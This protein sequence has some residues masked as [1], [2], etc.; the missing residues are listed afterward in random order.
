MIILVSFN[1]NNKLASLHCTHSQQCVA[2][3]HCTD[4]LSI[5]VK[6]VKCH[7]YDGFVC[8]GKTL[9]EVQRIQGIDSVSLSVSATCFH[10][11]FRENLRY[12]ANTLGALYLWH[13]F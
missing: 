2:A 9:P 1:P 3:V 8:P 7:G 12:E 10:F 13:C 5:I 6:V 11:N 4:L